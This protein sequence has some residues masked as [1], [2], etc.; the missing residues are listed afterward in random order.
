VPW[1][2]SRFG[3]PE[4]WA[5]RAARAEEALTVVRRL[6]TGEELDWT[7]PHF[8]VDRVRFQPVD[9]PIWASGWWPRRA[10]IRAA[11]GADGMFPI[12]RDESSPLGFRTPSPDEV[13]GLREA[14]VAAGAR[15][16]GD[17]ALWSLGAPE[18]VPYQAY[19]DA[20]VTWWLVDGCRIDPGELTRRVASGPSMA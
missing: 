5:Y 8:R 2:Y 10:P 17:F 3:E 7:G 16:D 6:L 4:A 14:F 12:S 11:Q 19:Q 15:S 9:V 13:A 1:D 18:P 20:G